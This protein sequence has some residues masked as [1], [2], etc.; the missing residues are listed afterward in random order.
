MSEARSFFQDILDGKE[1]A[2]FIARNSQYAAFMEKKPL[3]RGHVVV[4]PVRHVDFVFDLEDSEIGGLFQFAGRIARAIRDSIPCKKVAVG[5]LGLEVRH[6]HVHLVPV[7]L[8]CRIK[9]HPAKG[10][11]FRRRI[12]RGRRS[13][14]V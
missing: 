1:P 2:H 4:L 12:Q 3:K 11:I 7:G 14:T 13:D 5:V 9:L 6:A 8:G 10:L